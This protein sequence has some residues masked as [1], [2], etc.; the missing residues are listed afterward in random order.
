[1]ASG[2]SASQ[3]H[4]RHPAA[5]AG[6]TG[7]GIHRDTAIAALVD[8]PARSGGIDHAHLRQGRRSRPHRHAARADQSGRQQAA[9]QSTEANRSGA[10]ADVEYWRAAGHA[11]PGAG[12]CRCDQPAGVR[13]GAEL[14]EDRAR[15]SSPRSTR[16]SARDGSGSVTTAWSRRRTGLSAT[17]RSAPG[18]SRVGDDGD[19]DG[20]RQF[21][22]RGVHRGAARARSRSAS[23]AA[24]AATRCRRQGRGRESDLVCRAA[25][26]SCDPDRCSSRASSR[27]PRRALRSQQFIRAQDRLEHGARV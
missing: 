18:R 14:V 11:A 19:H 25:R 21:V 8:D 20:R 1:M 22:A 16:R 7:L 4:R 13:A 3:R 17:S 26:R 15:R 5:Q 27:T 6:R 12:R 23:R 2:V 24:G 9:V 10:E